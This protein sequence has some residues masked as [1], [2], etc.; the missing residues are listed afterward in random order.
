MGHERQVS[1][2]SLV[3][4]SLSNPLALS[5]LPDDWGWYGMWSFQ[6]ILRI[7]TTWLSHAGNEG[8]SVIRLQ[9]SRQSKSWDDVFDEDRGHDIRCLLGC[10]I[11]LNPPCERIHYG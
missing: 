10:G 9:G 3:S 11:C 7:S 1:K 6:V 2:V 4:W 5:T 8:R